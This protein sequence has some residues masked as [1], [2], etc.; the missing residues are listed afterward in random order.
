LPLRHRWGAIEQIV[1]TYCNLALPSSTRL[2]FDYPATPP[3][4]GQLTFS[5]G[6]STPHSE[7]RIERRM[8]A[9]TGLIRTDWSALPS[10]QRTWLARLGIQRGRESCNGGRL[11]IKLRDQGLNVMVDCRDGSSNMVQ[12]LG[13]VVL[14][15]I[16]SLRRNK[17]TNG[18]NWPADAV[19]TRHRFISASSEN[20]F[21]TPRKYPR[22][23]PYCGANTPMPVWPRTK[24]TASNITSRRI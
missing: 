5:P 14:S 4:A 18:T 12:R 24:K 6:A 8:L 7:F 20:F 17:R 19:F 11:A 23:G 13:N 3:N 9:T 1:E 16:V 2:I 10:R 22:R 15:V 21:D